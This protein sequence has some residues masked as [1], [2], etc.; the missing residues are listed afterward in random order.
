MND[1]DQ[2][3]ENLYYLAKNTKEEDLS[4][5]LEAFQRILDSDKPSDEWCFKSVKQMSKVLF[6][7]ERLDEVP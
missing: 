2:N 6:K 3:L 4:A 7:L 1:V 5:S